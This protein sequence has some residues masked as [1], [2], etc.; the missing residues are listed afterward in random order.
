[1]RRSFLRGISQGSIAVHP[2]LAAVYFVLAL[3]AE[4]G[5]ELIRLADMVRP[6]LVSLGLCIVTWLVARR[7]TQDSRKGA[8][9]ATAAT[10][11]FAVFGALEAALR[12]P[13]ELIG[14][15]LGLF[16]VLL[17]TVVA[18]GAM[19]KRGRGSPYGATRYL[20]LVTALLVAY[21]SVQVARD[22]SLSETF[23]A[24][25]T[26][27]VHNEAS[28]APSSGRLP[29]I[30]LI[31][32]DKY[33]GSRVLQSHYGFDNEP[34]ED[35]L[36]AR[37]FIVPSSAQANYIHTS[38]ALASMLNLEYLDDLPSRVG[39][40]NGDWEPV[41]P[42][43]ENHRLAQFLQGVGYRYIFF[44]SAFA[45]TRESR[46]ADVQIPLPSQIRPE[47][48]AVWVW[49]TPIPVL[50]AA[51]CKLLGC[52]IYHFSYTPE[53]AE[54][55]DWKFAR[56]PEV[57]GHERPVFVLAHLTLPHEPYVYDEACGHREPY[58]PLDDVKDTLKL[59]G[60]YV[61]QIKC[62]NTKLLAL[63]DK[64]LEGADAPP[65]IILQADHGHGRLGRLAPGLEDTAPW[66]VAERR[67]VFAA[68]AL[69]GVPPAAVSDS[70]SPVNVTRLLLRHYFAA[71]LAQL[72]DVTYWSAWA[73]PYRFT[74][75]R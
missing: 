11:W 5:S 47:F 9:V 21:S 42:L 20:N 33:T 54:L 69:P 10:V 27:A 13:L 26:P 28:L 1:M 16:I 53:S 19:I 48:E 2:P 37:G 73:R 29:D 31:I 68:Y 4:N 67:A 60:A 22:A 17:Y 24:A 63:V 51:A 8:L 56:L 14:G 66:Q 58:W 30:Y 44:P 70:I 32:L 43:V 3:A 50:H 36:R 18:L 65:V 52:R 39:V 75:I 41:Y 23:A 64:L 61:A 15:P 38:L 71:D 34:F 59:K 45:A 62:L 25:R 49:T 12:R 74:R 57:M 40:D 72:A 6:L 46:I 7:V 55:L 35:S